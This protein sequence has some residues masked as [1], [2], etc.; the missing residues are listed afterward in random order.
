MDNK[1]WCIHTTEY[2]LATKW[3]ELLNSK[4]M[5]KSQKYYVKQKKTD[6]KE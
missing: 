3:N 4:N 2:Y 1:L 5:D 6:T